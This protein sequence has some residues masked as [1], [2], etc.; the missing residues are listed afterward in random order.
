[1]KRPPNPAVPPSGRLYTTA[2]RE[3]LSGHSG[4][5]IAVQDLCVRSRSCDH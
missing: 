1:Y 2:G 3:V 5:P 4:T